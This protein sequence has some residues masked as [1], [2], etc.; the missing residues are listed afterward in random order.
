MA[1]LYFFRPSKIHLQRLF[2]FSL[3]W[4]LGALLETLDR[5]KF[6]VYLNDNFDSVLDLPSLED[7][8]EATI[9]DFYVTDEGI[10][11]YIL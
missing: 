8:P 5:H 6:H 7:Q 9:F 1:L 3:V 10:Y 11:I 2:T 4:G